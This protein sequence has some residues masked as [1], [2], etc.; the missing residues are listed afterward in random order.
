M[1]QNSTS[2]LEYDGLLRLKSSHLPY[3]EGPP[4]S[5]ASWILQISLVILIRLNTTAVRTYLVPYLVAYWLPE[6]IFAGRVTRIQYYE[7]K[8]ILIQGESSLREIFPQE[9]QSSRF[10][11]KKKHVFRLG[12]FNFLS[13]GKSVA[14]LIISAIKVTSGMNKTFYSNFGLNWQSS[15]NKIKNGTGMVLV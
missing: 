15:V 13:S 5:I 1:Q 10:L 6:S 3:T 9:I 8:V 12:L 11:L 7:A 2:S 14:C 4:I